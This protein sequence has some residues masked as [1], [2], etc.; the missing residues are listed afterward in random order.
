MNRF[1][2]IG[3]ALFAAAI[4]SPSWAADGNGNGFDDVFERVLAVEFCP[5]LILDAGDN[6]VS[7]EPV[8]IMGPLWATMNERKERGAYKVV[9]DGR[10]DA[11]QTVASGVYFYK[12]AA[13]S[14][15]DTKKMTILK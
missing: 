5:A 9:W 7:P 8:E 2:V 3:T 10:N 15:I 11:G 13:G 12:I 1:G 4:S 14:F 6:H